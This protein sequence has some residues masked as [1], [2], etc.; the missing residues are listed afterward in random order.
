MRIAGRLQIGERVEKERRHSPREI[1]IEQ[2]QALKKTK[3]D[4]TPLLYSPAEAAKALGM[5]KSKLYALWKD[6]PINAPPWFMIGG[7]RYVSIEALNH[8]VAE[9]SGAAAVLQ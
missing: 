2:N 6:D 8:W 9:R 4:V 5:S 3:P 1:M 7:N